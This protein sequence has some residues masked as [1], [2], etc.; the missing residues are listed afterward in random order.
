M[1][2]VGQG[3]GLAACTFESLAVTSCTTK[4]LHC[5]HTAHLRVS[6]GPLNKQWL[7]PCTTLTSAYSLL[8]YQL[9]AVAGALYSLNIYCETMF[10]LLHEKS[11]PLMGPHCSIHPLKANWLVVYNQD[12]ECLMHGTNSDFTENRLCFKPKGL[13]TNTN[14]MIQSYQLYWDQTEITRA[15]IQPCK[16]W[17]VVQQ[18]WHH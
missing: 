16:Q 4:I 1:H 8:K 17:W 3:L 2:S 14:I 18:L 5:T 12:G 10:F 15:F 6:Y 11:V 9:S 7:L 13:I